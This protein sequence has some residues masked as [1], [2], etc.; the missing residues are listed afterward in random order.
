MKLAGQI[1]LLT[2]S[3]SVNAQTVSNLDTT[4][5][6]SSFTK[7]LNRSLFGDSLASSFCI[8]IKDEVPAHLHE[9]HSEHVM[10]IE[11]EAMMTLGNNKFVIRKNDLIFIP[12]KTIHAVKNT[13]KTPLKVLS[14]QSPYF[15]G[16][17]RVFVDPK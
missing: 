14:I 17:D 12:K 4:G 16:G 11:G 15:D 13:G 10:V 8:L 1:L 7:I 6:R 5:S 2:C 9:H 3:F